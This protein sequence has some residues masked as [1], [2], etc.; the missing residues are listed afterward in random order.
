LIVGAGCNAVLEN[1]CFCLSEPGDAVL[2]PTPYYAAF[3][4]DLGARAGLKVEPV[5][6]FS[7]YKGG[8]LLSSHMKEP[9]SPIPAEA[10]YPS[11][12]ALSAA[13]D[14]AKKTTGRPPSV[15]LLSHPNNPLGI[16]YPAHVVQDCIDWCRERN[17]HLVSDEIYA[18][19]VYA[20]GAESE[21][22][23]SAANLSIKSGLG[24][25][26]HIVY[27]LSKDFG[28]SGLRVGA[29]YTENEDIILP[30]QKLNDLCQISS[31]TQVLV[32]N[33]LSSKEGDED[34]ASFWTDEFLRENH[35]R[36]RSRRDAL[37][38]VLD[39][40]SIPYLAGEAGLFLW[41]D[42][43]E[44]LEAD[45]GTPADQERNLYLDMIESGILFTPGLSMKTECAG[46]FRCVFTAALDH[47][48]ELALKR[49]HD[50]ITSR[51]ANS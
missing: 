8:S 46:F 13:Y 42:L 18:G 51:K 9:S 1:L 7:H 14:R 29:C 3:E 4:F 2:V 24:P 44:L 16:C 39:E 33:M 25:N 30:L 21:E 22:F 17:V 6:T 11:R 43:R 27:A 26:L 23:V 40:C 12:S 15:L 10:Y 37:Q 31:T 45:A 49:I 5:T 48:F 47:E 28:L 32:E 41:I 35:E 50:F 19:S 36:L 34:E 38:N 20:G